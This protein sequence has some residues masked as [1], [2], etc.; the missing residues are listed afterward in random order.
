VLEKRTTP[1]GMQ[2]KKKKR[3]KQEKKEKSRIELQQ[4]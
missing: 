4:C 2:K 3:K 1:R